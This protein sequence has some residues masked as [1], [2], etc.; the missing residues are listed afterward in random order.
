VWI[1]SQVPLDDAGVRA[2]V[3]EAGYDI[4]TAS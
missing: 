3:Q 4:I 1:T 2:A